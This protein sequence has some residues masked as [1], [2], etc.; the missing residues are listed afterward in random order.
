VLLEKMVLLV[1]WV[2]RGYKAP[3]VILGVSLLNIHFQTL[4]I[5]PHLVK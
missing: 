5:T 3:L 2:H 4:L 1:L